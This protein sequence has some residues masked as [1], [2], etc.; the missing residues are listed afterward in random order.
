MG[1][2]IEER[3]ADCAVYGLSMRLFSMQIMACKRH[4]RFR[5][6]LLKYTD[7]SL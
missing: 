3:I 2:S 1:S 6:L 7:E 5:S 4:A